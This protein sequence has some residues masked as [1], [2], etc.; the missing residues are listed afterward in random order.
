MSLVKD[1]RIRFAV[2]VGSIVKDLRILWSVAEVD[3][4]FLNLGFIQDMDEAMLA[5]IS[6]LRVYDRV[7]GPKGPGTSGRPVKAWFRRPEADARKTSYPYITVDLLDFRPAYDRM[8]QG[9]VEQLHYTPHGYDAPPDGSFLST[10]QVPIPYDF[11]WQVTVVSMFIEHDRQLDMLL[12]ADDR[13]PPRG[14]YLPVNDTVRYMTV[15]KSPN[16]DF[17]RQTAGGNTE[18]VFR[19]IYT[20]TATAELFQRDLILYGPPTTLDISVVVKPSA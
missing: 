1:L 17:N 20:V 8:Q 19:K 2:D 13:L 10:D 6:G 9:Y 7:S 5:K 3:Q 11:I 18:R 16:A 14:A 4:P 15:S 12:L